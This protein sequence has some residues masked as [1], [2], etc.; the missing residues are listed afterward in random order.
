MATNQLS[1][2][3][4]QSHQTRR[5]AAVEIIQE[6]FTQANVKVLDPQEALKGYEAGDN[7]L[8][9]DIKDD[10]NCV[11]EPP[12]DPRS[13]AS[14]L[15]GLFREFPRWKPGSTINFAAYA[16]GYTEP[17][18]A[19]FAALRLWEAAKEWNEHNLGVKFEWV[20]KLDEATF[21]L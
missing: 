12:F 13:A 21:V 4:A 11:T 20:G 16:D 14:I 17:G 7:N 19:K 10:Y 3:T 18:D 1:R 15:V 6:Q 9:S 8:D 5:A 2:D